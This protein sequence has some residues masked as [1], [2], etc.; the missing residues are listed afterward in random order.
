MASGVGT[1]THEAG[2]RAAA[3]AGDRTAIV[4][5]RASTAE[6]AR[7]RAADAA[8]VRREDAAGRGDARAWA[9][10][11][12]RVAIAR[13]GSDEVVF[14]WEAAATM[15]VGAAL[16][17]WG[18]LAGLWSRRRYVWLLAA[19]YGVGLPLRAYGA[20]EATR[21]DGRVEFAWVWE[22]PAR[23]A[24]TIGHLALV[25]LL[26]AHPR[27][28]AWLRPFAAA[29]RTAL[30]LYVAQTLIVSW[31]VF[32]PMGLGLYGRLGWAEMMLLALAVD[33]L[34]VIAA[35][36]YL[37]RYRIAPVEWAWRSLVEGRRLPIR[38]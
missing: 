34:L 27:A 35:I 17:R 10:G 31:L 24:T 16:F 8:A 36:L 23:L 19:G 28:M 9:T 12:W 4:A 18:V 2:V 37:R 33:A 14:V 32:S 3:A 26:A 29:G 25:M 6:R 1:V 21:F 15:L 7:L 22:E 13:L 30:T 11:Q 20:W 5:I 38:R